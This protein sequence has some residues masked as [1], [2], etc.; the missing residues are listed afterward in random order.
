ML[1]EKIRFVIAGASTTLF[2]YALYAALLY[3][4][5]AAGPAYVIAYVAGIGWAFVV[6]SRWVFRTPMT[7]GRLLK[8]PAVYV[9]Q[10]AA[11]FALFHLFHGILGIHELAV[12]LLIAAILIPLT[13]LISRYILTERRAPRIGG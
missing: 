8:F 12:P 1:A 11:S 6:N 5:M 3:L 9:V 13:Y 10:A 2:S 4:G 7:L